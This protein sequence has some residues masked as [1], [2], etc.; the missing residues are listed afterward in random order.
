MG[1]SLNS[2][3]YLYNTVTSPMSLLHIKGFDVHYSLMP[4]VVIV[5]LMFSTE[6]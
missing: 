1:R 6:M 2:L 4:V 3:I 5:K